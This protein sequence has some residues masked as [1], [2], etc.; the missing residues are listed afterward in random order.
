MDDNSSIYDIVE[1]QLLLR[2]Y[3]MYCI[4]YIEANWITPS[5]QVVY[6]G[7]KA[8]IV[9]VSDTSVNFSKN[10]KIVLSKYRVYNILI[11]YQLELQDSGIYHCSGSK[12]NKTFD[13]SSE[14]LVGGNLKF[15]LCILRSNNNIHFF[16]WNIS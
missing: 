1:L 4:G 10:G 8:I 3:F 13:V 16:T 7:A 9:C 11:L 5:L 12:S 2:Y 15:V 14:L 6:E